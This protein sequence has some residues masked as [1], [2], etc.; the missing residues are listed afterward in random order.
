M[1]LSAH[2]YPLKHA[3]GDFRDVSRV[4]V[5]TPSPRVQDEAP[6]LR[7]VSLV[8]H[9]ADVLI[10]E[11]LFRDLRE[12]DYVNTALA[13]LHAAFPHADDRA[14]ALDALGWTGRKLIEV[15]EI[16]PPAPL[17]GGAFDGL[18]SRRLRSSYVDAGERA[19]RTWLNAT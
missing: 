11:R 2:F 9:L 12:A 17:E 3:I 8:T 15:I 16:R 7:G 1:A 18:F 4:F 14:R 13:R 6:R 10:Q 5:I 19:A